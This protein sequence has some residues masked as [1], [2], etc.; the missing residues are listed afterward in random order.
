MSNRWILVYDDGRTSAIHPTE[1]EAEQTGATG[2]PQG[3]RSP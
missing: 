3:R 2:G 1:V